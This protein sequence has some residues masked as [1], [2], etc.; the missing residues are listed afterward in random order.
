MTIFDL[1]QQMGITAKRETS[2]EYSSPCPGCG[3]KDR[4]RVW[5]DTDTYWCRQ[6]ERKGDN[7]QFCRDFL[8]VSYWKACQIVGKTPKGRIT[9]FN[10]SSKR[11]PGGWH[12]RES[13]KP[14]DLW[15]QKADNFATWAQ[16]QLWTRMG[17]A[18]KAFLNNRG[19]C[20]E[21][22]RETRLGYCPRDFFPQ[23]EAWGLETVVK[24]NGKPKKLWLPQGIVVP[25]FDEDGH[26]VRVRIRRDNPGEGP[27][28]YFTPGSSV[29]PMVFNPVK[30]V[31][32]VVES[33]LD[34]VLLHQDAGDL[35]SA[36]ALGSSST[37]PDKKTTEH[38]KNVERILV[39]LD[40]DEA[41]AKQ[42]WVWW[43]KNFPNAERWPVV[44]GKDPTEARQSGLSLRL[45]ILA[46]DPDL[47][48][49]EER[50]AIMEM[51]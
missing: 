46:A 28:Y 33:E 4:F 35:V 12:P 21:I 38:L 39:A 13:K 27:R 24:E 36:V 40:S 32:V 44:N 50:A 9:S 37:R 51:M 20:D 8:N 18:A 25:S 30:K 23:R 49:R 47:E 6:C 17:D 29:A 26:I 22:I 45:W 31:A 34:A 10:A 19:L 15:R 43:G 41:G 16:E 42:F 1:L 5:P 11:G 7:V 3:G 2:T 14:A 48:D